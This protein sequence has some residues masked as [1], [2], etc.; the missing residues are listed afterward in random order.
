MKIARLRSSLEQSEAA[1][2]SVE[3]ELTIVKKQ[4]ADE[5]EAGAFKC[6]SLTRE[7]EDLKG[8]LPWR[9]CPEFCQNRKENQ[10]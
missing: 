4:L 3:L 1:R 5:Q 7:N 6:S 9:L 8:M 10:S 2:R